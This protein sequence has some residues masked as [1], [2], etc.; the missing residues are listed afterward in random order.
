MK[1]R[2]N[3]S[4]PNYKKLVQ[5]G[6]NLKSKLNQS[7]S[8]RYI[9]YCLDW[10]NFLLKIHSNCTANTPVNT[11]FMKH[12]TDSHIIHYSMRCESAWMRC[13]LVRCPIKNMFT[14]HYS[15]LC[16]HSFF[17]NHVHVLLNPFSFKI[18]PVFLPTLKTKSH[19][20]SIEEE[21]L[22]RE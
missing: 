7:N 2:L 18:F 15:L 20:C 9:F 19:G 14:Y 16:V 22:Y 10:M 4:N 17:I 21:S 8:N 6:S 5:I 3:W 12:R 11:S 1:N 13:K